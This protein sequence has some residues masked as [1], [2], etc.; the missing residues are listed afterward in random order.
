MEDRTLRKKAVEG[1]GGLRG[2]GGKEDLAAEEEGDKGREAAPWPRVGEFKGDKGVFGHVFV[3]EP[4]GFF[5]FFFFFFCYY[6][7]FFFPFFLSLFLLSSLLS[8]ICFVGSL[9]LA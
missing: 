6:S 9:G 2:A 3:K 5:F 8:W 7:C 4:F 1:E